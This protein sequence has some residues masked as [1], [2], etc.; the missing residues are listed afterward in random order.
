MQTRIMLKQHSTAQHSTA[1]HSTAQH[2][3]VGNCAI[4]V[5]FSL[6]TLEIEYYLDDG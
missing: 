6:G 2:S 5:S 4:L 3:T 1:Q